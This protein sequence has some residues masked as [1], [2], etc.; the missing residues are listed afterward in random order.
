METVEQRKEIQKH[1]GRGSERERR[2]RERSVRAV[3]VLKTLLLQSFFF[4]SHR[5]VFHL[6]LCAGGL[7]LEARRHWNPCSDLSEFCNLISD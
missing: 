7:S 3:Q 6:F 1:L 2:T 5:F 4:C